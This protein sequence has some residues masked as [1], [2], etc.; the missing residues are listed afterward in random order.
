SPVKK[1]IARGETGVAPQ[2]A[3]EDWSNENNVFQFIRLEDLAYDRNQPR[4][5]YVADTGRSRVVPDP[6]TG[7]MMRGPG[8]TVGLADHGRIF[9]FVFNKKDPRKV[10]S[11]SVFADGDAPPGSPEFV[12]I[13][14]PDNLDTSMHSLMVQEDT[15]NALIWNLNFSTGMWSVVATVN[16]PG[17]ESS[18]IVDASEWFGSGSWLLDVQGSADIFSELDPTKGVISKLSSGQLMLL[19]VPGS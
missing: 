5:V 9:R 12:P 8:G 14:S 15:S 13:T 7:R 17:G 1:E 18:G 10:D 6:N 11:F 4:I 3:L 2:Q 19:T 16:D